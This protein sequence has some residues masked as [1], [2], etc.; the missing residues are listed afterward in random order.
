M[1]VF[2]FVVVCVVVVDIVFFRYFVV[3]VESIFLTDE[4]RLSKDPGYRP[5]GRAGLGTSV[6]LL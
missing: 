1:L 3:A 4:I 6:L 2:V 5:L